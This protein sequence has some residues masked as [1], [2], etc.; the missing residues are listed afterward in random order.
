M[1]IHSIV[2]SW[3]LFPDKLQLGVWPGGERKFYA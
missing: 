1:S 3:M 2:R